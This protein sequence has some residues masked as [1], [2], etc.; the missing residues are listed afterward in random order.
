MI[1]EH[2][3]SSEMNLELCDNNI[4]KP[5]ELSSELDDKEHLESTVK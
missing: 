1:K 4:R 3:K 5:N 2:F